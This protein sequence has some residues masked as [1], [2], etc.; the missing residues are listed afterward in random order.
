VFTALGM[1]DMS[2]W[3][4]AERIKIGHPDLP[5]VLVTGWGTSLDQD[6]VRRR[7]ISAVVHKPFEIVDLLRTA[8][9]V[10]AA[11]EEGVGT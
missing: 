8:A 10:L 3:E 6:E 2:G 4:V 5:V 9:L 1:P 11:K 7:G